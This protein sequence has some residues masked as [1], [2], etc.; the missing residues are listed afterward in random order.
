MKNHKNDL[1]SINP[2]ENYNAP[3][4]PTLSDDNSAA[5]KKM[6]NRWKKNAKV[7][8]CVGIMGTM[9][10]A[11]L[12]YPL[13]QAPNGNNDAENAVYNGQAAYS[14]YSETDLI[15]RLHGGGGGSA[16]YVV[17]FTE[18][19]AF[20][21]IRSQLEA[22]GLDFDAVPPDYKIEPE[23]FGWNTYDIDL[24]DSRH[25]VG[26]SH[27]TR[28]MNNQPFYSHGGDRLA[29]RVAEKFAE[30]TDFPVGVF[31]TPEWFPRFDAMDRHERNENGEWD[32]IPHIPP[33]DEQI[34]EAKATARP[35]LEESLTA[36]V[37]EFI[38]FLHAEGI[39]ESVIDE[40]AEIGVTFN[41]TPIEF[42]VQPIIVNNRTMVPFRVIFEALEM[43]VDWNET[44]RTA[45]GRVNRDGGLRVELTI[46]SNIALVNGRP[47]QLDSPAIIHNDRTMVPLRFIAEATGANVAWDEDSRT[48]RI[49][50]ENYV[51]IS[52][53]ELSVRA[54]GGGAPPVPF[55]VVHLTEQEAFG[56]IRELL[57]VEGINLDTPTTER[58]AVVS[59]VMP[60]HPMIYNADYWTRETSVNVNLSDEEKGVGIAKLTGWNRN[61]RFA[62]LAREAFAEQVS[63][64]T[65]G[66]FH[67]PE[68]DLGGV[69][70]DWETED[71][72]RDYDRIN[73]AKAQAAPI[74]RERLIA[75][76][77][78]FIEFLRSEGI[79]D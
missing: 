55:Y 8:A 54:H 47:V 63:D 21:I 1:L 9:T 41:G 39:L 79:I 18:Q 52:G 72:S 45:S 42:D 33:T 19:E 11:G 59:E 56:I 7:I 10:L 25:R 43:E 58:T 53:L 76:V 35:I 61:S 2:M 27:I 4:I 77:R 71:G 36:Q 60:P 3:R 13:A 26:V 29:N 62:G 22:V 69:A 32:V 70:W 16:F 78:E 68:L 75:Q 74:L 17:Y 65:V 6:P 24:F 66:V 50:D 15:F 51:D 73:E 30:L 44:R 57:E 46:D 38:D 67:N 14:G 40:T 23:G 37:Q 34:A 49:T 5:L 48:V 12:A 20:N 31:Y 64:K 28:E